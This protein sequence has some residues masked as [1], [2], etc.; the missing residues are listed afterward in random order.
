MLAKNGYVRT[1]VITKNITAI[2]LASCYIQM[3]K[4][5]PSVELF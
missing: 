2:Q 4:W 5:N 3:T 1:Q